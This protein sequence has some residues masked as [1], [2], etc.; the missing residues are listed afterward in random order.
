MGGLK[1]RMTSRWA[2]TERVGDV[3]VHV[4]QRNGRT[5]IALDQRALDSTELI[6]ATK[7]ILDIGNKTIKCLSGISSSIKLGAGEELGARTHMRRAAARLCQA[8]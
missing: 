2:S 7:I 5:R 6:T 1:A 8:A 4:L 3:C